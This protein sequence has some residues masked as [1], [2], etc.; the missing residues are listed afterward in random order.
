M[1]TRY[2]SLFYVFVGVCFISCASFAFGQAADIRVVSLELDR[3]TIV[4]GCRGGQVPTAGS[5]DDSPRTLRVKATISGSAAPDSR[6][7]TLVTGGKTVRINASE[8]DWHLEDVG[9]GTYTITVSPVSKEGEHGSPKT[10]TVAVKQCA[11][12]HVDECRK[13]TVSGP[14]ELVTAGEKVEFTAKVT[15]Q[16]NAT[17]NWSVSAGTITSGQGTATIMVEPD[18]SMAGQALTATVDVP[19]LGGIACESSASETVAF[20]SVPS[21]KLVDEFS[22]ARTG[23]EDV[24]A[25]LDSFYNELNNDPSSTGAIIVYSEAPSHLSG[26]RRQK[27]IRNHIKM[28]NFDATRFTFLDSPLMKDAKTEFWL[29]PAGASLPAVKEGI[30]SATISKVSSQEPNT[31]YLYAGEYM[32]GIP[33]CDGDLY[34]IAAF[35]EVLNSEPISKGR[36]VISETSAGKFSRKRAE[37]YGELKKN[38]VSANRLSAIFKK[39]RP[40]AALESVELWVIPVRK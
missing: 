21:A 14:S 6:L 12:G 20:M 38:G 35:A 11:C 8:F 30:K 29:V 32:D 5:C 10:A 36:L 16:R 2:Y 3:T 22:T 27:Q 1:L 23:C 31:P 33:G 15:G 26:A 34:D 4:T 39:V 9:A 28:R 18:T 37:I 13:V 25:R 7:E 40:M 17:Y 24:F 19:N